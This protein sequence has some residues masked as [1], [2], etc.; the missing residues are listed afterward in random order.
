MPAALR[1][2]SHDG[3]PLARAMAA[4]ALATGANTGSV[5]LQQ[6][7]GFLTRRFGRRGWYVHLALVLPLWGRFLSLLRPIA[8]RQCWLLPAPLR[9]LGTPVLVA[10]GALWLAAY[11]K[12]G[13]ARTGNGNLFGHG[14]TAPVTGG[15]YRFRANPMYDAYVLA[16]VG[17]ALRTRSAA[18]LVLAGEAALLCH[19][20]EARAENR[21]IAEACDVARSSRH[22]WL[23]SRWRERMGHRRISA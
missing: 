11:A 3:Q 18:F 13:G 1:C 22:R 23:P 16:L 9:P 7:T 6:R 17:L 21:A 14:D 10:A 4:L 15:I 12:L 5:V 19:G 20:I 8:R 2:H